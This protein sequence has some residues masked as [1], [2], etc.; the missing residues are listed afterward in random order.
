M[1]KP[2]YPWSLFH[3]HD[4]SNFLFCPP[5]QSTIVFLIHFFI[6]LFLIHFFICLCIADNCVKCH[7]QDGVAVVRFDTP[8]SKVSLK[9]GKKKKKYYKKSSEISLY[10][11]EDVISLIW[12][13]YFLCQVNVLSEKL[14]T[15][16]VEVSITRADSAYSCNHY[17]LCSLSHL[18]AFMFTCLLPLLM[19]IT[20]QVMQGVEKNP[21]VKSV[22]LASAKPGCWIAGADIKYVGQY[23]LQIIII[24][25]CMHH[26][27]LILNSI[28]GR[29]HDLLVR[30]ITMFQLHAT[31]V[32]CYS[33]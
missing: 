15:E 9:C 20:D 31:P 2:C 11:I 7:I 1:F 33:L 27:Y 4:Q 8:D 5:N 32:Q 10:S 24:V 18:I 29:Y 13:S 26:W 23:G 30:K 6:C 16:L 25:K 19:W 22:V 14:T 3:D 17:R 21:D 28:N 12:I